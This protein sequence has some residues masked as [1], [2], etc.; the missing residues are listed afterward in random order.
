MRDKIFK[1]E[2]GSQQ[3]V[4]AAPRWRVAWALSAMEEGPLPPGVIDDEAT[5][6]EWTERLRLELEI[7]ALL[8]ESH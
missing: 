5:Q 4:R 6:A 8:G 1:Y 7:R 3:P 2:D